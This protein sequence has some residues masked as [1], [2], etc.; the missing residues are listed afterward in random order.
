MISR[1][2]VIHD[3]RLKIIE[4]YKTYWQPSIWKNR[5]LTLDLIDPVQSL[6]IPI[7]YYELCFNPNI[8]FQYVL[9]HVNEPWCWH[10]LTSMESI[11]IKDI[12]DN[13]TLPWTRH[14]VNI[15]QGVSLKMMQDFPLF[16]WDLQRMSYVISFEDFIDNPGLPW[17]Y[18][19]LSF[20]PNIPIEYVLVHKH[21][22]VWDWNGVIQNIKSMKQVYDA[23]QHGVD[24]YWPA[25][26]RHQ[27][28]TFDDIVNNKHLP[29]SW[30]CI[31]QN[32]NILIQNVLDHPELPWNWS[33]LVHNNKHFTLDII[34]EY[35]PKD[36]EFSFGFYPNQPTFE[37]IEKHLKEYPWSFYRLCASA[38]LL[39]VADYD[40]NE[41]IMKHFAARR[42][43][44]ICK[45]AFSNPEFSICRK[46]LLRE[47]SYLSV[48]TIPFILDE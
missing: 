33:W 47:F 22:H 31:S 39:E 26:T 4:K 37:F 35:C 18:T 40:Y 19:G 36:C 29:W 14:L 24:L 2:D 34:S 27:H 21:S 13:P 45:M 5:N 28:I 8:T 16:P 48:C 15:K 38:S 9:E 32:P 3:L 23:L 20:N 25:L 43:Q 46:R 6:G 11:S 12:L 1:Y 17:D 7:D 41:Y 44:R 42:I 10:V 30:S